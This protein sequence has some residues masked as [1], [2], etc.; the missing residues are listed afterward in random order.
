MT[1]KN[2]QNQTAH[3]SSRTYSL[4]RFA[5]LIE[6]SQCSENRLFRYANALVHQGVPI[7]S[8]NF[9]AH[10]PLEIMAKNDGLS[11][12]RKITKRFRREPYNWDCWGF[13]G[14]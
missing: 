9:A 3:H 10:D 7:T 13:G 6:N 5:E 4:E 14:K 8:V 2:Y 12:V 1:N 11:R